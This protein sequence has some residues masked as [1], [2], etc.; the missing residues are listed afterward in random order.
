MT[1]GD[2]LEFLVLGPLEAHARGRPL[3]LGGPRQR[4]LLARLLVAVNEMVPADRLVEDVWDGHPPRTCAN[5]LHVHVSRLR[6]LLGHDALRTVAAGYVLSVPAG[7]I[8]AVRFDELRAAAGL[9]PAAGA[10]ERLSEALALWRGPAFANVAEAF[11][12]AEAARLEELRLVALER[13]VEADLVLGRHREL[14]AELEA[15]LAAEPFREGLRAQLMIALYRSGRQA[16]ALR[17]YR[18]GRRRLAGE[19]GI[20]PTPQLRRLEQAILA[21]DPSLDWQIRHSND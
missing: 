7:R 11:V 2:E 18:E 19:L 8:D 4:A 6:R 5:A 10:A 12:R 13:R 3:A 16:A 9:L 20:E 15:L 14:C 1:D 17:V 21:Q